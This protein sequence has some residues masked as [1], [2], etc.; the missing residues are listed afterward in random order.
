MVVRSFLVLV[1]SFTAGAC[2]RSHNSDAE[3]TV[4]KRAAFDFSCTPEQIQITKLDDSGGVRKL[5]TQVG[6]EGNA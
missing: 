6:A 2:Y 4:R 5:S 3:Q 1:L